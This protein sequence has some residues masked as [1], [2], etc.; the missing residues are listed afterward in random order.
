[1]KK[2]DLS[3]AQ[4]EDFLQ[5]NKKLFESGKISRADYIKARNDHNKKLQ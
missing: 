3:E 5:I 1:M 2:N 4:N